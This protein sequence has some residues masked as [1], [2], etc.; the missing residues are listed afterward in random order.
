MSRQI[1]LFNKKEVG[2][3][4]S[5]YWL[6]NERKNK[7][8]KKV[9]NSIPEGQVLDHL[10][11]KNFVGM[12]TLV[13]SRKAYESLEYGFD[14]NYE[15]IG[16]Y[17]L[18]LRLCEKWQ[19][20]AVQEPCSYYRWHGNNLSIKKMELNNDELF[21]WI[22]KMNKKEAF[23]NKKNYKY[24]VSLTFFYKCLIL[25]ISNRRISAFMLIKKIKYIKLKLKVIILL[26]IPSFFIKMLRS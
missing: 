17:D 6:I 25:I 23:K 5:N 14:E 8:P 21:S 1:N 15:I 20:A 4:C 22:E 13:V 11:R 10:L 18:V 2:L 26:L 16:D 19:L 9:F 24:L 7:I 12:S 3:V